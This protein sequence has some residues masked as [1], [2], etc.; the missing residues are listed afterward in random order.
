MSEFPNGLKPSLLTIILI[1][2][3]FKGKTK[4]PYAM[5]IS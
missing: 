1:L 2:T 5:R 4:V 3:Q